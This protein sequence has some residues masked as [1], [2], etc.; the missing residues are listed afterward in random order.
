MDEAAD[1]VLFAANLINSQTSS[2]Q[3]N[4][5]TLLNRTV[6][7]PNF[8]NSEKELHILALANQVSF[9]VNELYSQ[10]D[11]IIS[12]LIDAYNGKL[13]PSMISAQ[14]LKAQLVEIHSHLPKETILPQELTDDNIIQYYK[15]IK[16]RARLIDDKLVF[17]LRVPLLYKEKFQLFQLIPVPVQIENDTMAFIQ[18][19]AKYFMVTQRKVEYYM[20]N[21]MEFSSC[22]KY[23]EDAYCCV[24]NDPLYSAT[25]TLGN[26]ELKLL[27]FAKNLDSSCVIKR[28]P[29]KQY[30]SSLHHPIIYDELGSE[31]LNFMN[32]KMEK[33]CLWKI[34]SF[35]LHA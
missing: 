31:E 7:K 3:Q 11:I 26:C 5:F 21:E 12:V 19:S 32:K 8:S 23:T 16:T 20:L 29:K 14:Q 34:F 28:V 13:H 10:Q 17:E 33:S 27:K 30:W 22:I 18:P 15:H 24:F 2:M 6:V 9:M 35:M 25:E 1:N 4:L